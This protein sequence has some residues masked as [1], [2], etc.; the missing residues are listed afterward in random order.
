MLDPQ[1][2]LKLTLPVLAGVSIKNKE[3]RREQ[4]RRLL[5]L[6]SELGALMDGISEVDVSD[7]H[8]L[9]V[10]VA[11]NN[12]ALTLMLGDR[13]FEPRYRTFA[14]HRQDV[15]AVV[16]NARVLDMRLRGR[17]TAVVTEEPLEPARKGK[18]A[19]SRK[20]RRR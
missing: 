2:A 17:F 19:P 8:N 20:E 10:T 13:E 7:P 16:P 15:M 6:Q 11:Y 4:V 1:R 14:D 9:R 12:R 5:R 18:P 3:R